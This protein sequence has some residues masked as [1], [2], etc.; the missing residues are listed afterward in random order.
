MFAYGHGHWGISICE[1]VIIDAAQLKTSAQWVGSIIGG[2]VLEYRT[3]NIAVDVGMWDIVGGEEYSR[4]R[5]LSYPDSSVILLCFAINDRPAFLNI[6]REVSPV[7][8]SGAPINGTSVGPRS[9]AL[10]S[11]SSYLPCWLQNRCP[12]D[13]G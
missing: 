6:E 7:V 13:W 12:F 10:V 5:V 8:G 9:G 1:L 3:R 2:M 4:L 11:R